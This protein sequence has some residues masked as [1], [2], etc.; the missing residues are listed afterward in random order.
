[1]S[2]LIGN[3]DVC[4]LRF[5]SSIG[6]II[7]IA[8]RIYPISLESFFMFSVIEEHFREIGQLVLLWF[9]KHGTDATGKLFLDLFHFLFCRGRH[10]FSTQLHRVQMLPNAVGNGD[11]LI[12]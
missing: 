5:H 8:V 7:N 12:S 2:E 1:M 6:F 11:I 9:P 4:L 3:F 10:K